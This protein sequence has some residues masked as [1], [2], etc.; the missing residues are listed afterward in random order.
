MPVN[1]LRFIAD[2][3][4][5]TVSSLHWC[6]TESEAEVTRIYG[7]LQVLMNDV[8]RRSSMS[9]VALSAVSELQ[10]QITTTCGEG[11]QADITKL[12]SVL[13]RFTSDNAELMDLT[14]P[15]IEAL[16][17][18]DRLRQNLENA[19]KILAVWLSRRNEFSGGDAQKHLVTL[20]EEFLKC[21]TT[22]EERNIIRTMIEGLPPE[23]TAVDDVMMF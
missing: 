8:K 3:R 23:V 10:D 18:Q 11:G 12:V 13:K 5:F 17:F 15:I 21:T 14:S 4:D 9:D 2:V 22:A 19:G 16:Q 20:G 6:A 1:P 7:S